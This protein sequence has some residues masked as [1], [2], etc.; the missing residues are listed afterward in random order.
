MRAKTLV[1]STFVV[2]I[3]VGSSAPVN[4]GGGGGGLCSAMSSSQSVSIRDYCFEGVAHVTDPGQEVRMVNEGGTVHDVT[5]SDGSF[6]SGPLQPGETFKVTIESR[7]VV[8]Y[9][10]SLHGSPEGGGM[11]GVL[12]ADIGDTSGAVEATATKGDASVLDGAGTASAAADDAPTAMD[13]ALIAATNAAQSDA[14]VA[15]VVVTV[16]GMAVAFGLGLVVWAV[17][18]MP[19]DRRATS[20]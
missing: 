13:T 15:L 18:R 2:L 16:I 7:G 14:T 19:S 6:A 1:A 4:A 12:I 11:A 8:P 9:Y 17:G 5:A 20:P 3:V 10:C